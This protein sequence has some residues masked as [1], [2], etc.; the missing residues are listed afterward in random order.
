MPPTAKVKS[1][2]LLFAACAN[3][4]DILTDFRP[5]PVRNDAGPAVQV[6]F[7]TPLMEL[8][9]GALAHHLPR[10]MRDVR[11][12]EK[13]WLIGYTTRLAD[14]AGKTP[15]ENY[16][17]H[18]FLSDQRVDQHEDTELKG[19]YSDAFTPEV[20]VPAGYGIP[21]APGENLHWMPMFNNRGDAAVRVSMQ[22]RL[23]LIRD[24]D[25]TSAIKPLYA[26]LRSVQVPHLFFVEPGTDRREA[27]FRLPF[28]GRIHFMG[29]HLHPYGV[30]IELKNVTRDE[31]VWIGKRTRGP[32]SPMESYASPDGY[33]FRAGETYRITSVYNNPHKTKIDAMAGLFLLYSRD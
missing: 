14:A 16:L 13:V 21:I 8:E 10:A 5:S 7:S 15:L 22:V 31:Q 25:R 17:C 27:V 24:R 26:S 1:L 30:S 4:A 18:T 23:T 29:T 33:R 2:L 20:W 11:F 28:N 19:I 6:E 12:N 32:D 3:A 9:P